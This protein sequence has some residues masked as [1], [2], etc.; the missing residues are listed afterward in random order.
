MASIEKEMNRHRMFAWVLSGVEGMLIVSIAAQAVSDPLRII[1]DPFWSLASSMRSTRMPMLWIAMHLHLS[2]KTSCSGKRV[3]RVVVFLHAVVSQL[4]FVRYFAG[5]CWVAEP[6]MLSLFYVLFLIFS[7]L[8]RV[9]GMDVL[10]MERNHTRV[11]GLFVYIW[12]SIGLVTGE[13]MQLYAAS[14]VLVVSVVGIGSIGLRA[15]ALLARMRILTEMASAVPWRVPKEFFT[16]NVSAITY[17]FI[18]SI[19]DKV[20]VYNMSL[21]NLNLCE[22]G[23]EEND[24]IDTARFKFFQMSELAMKHPAVLRRIAKCHG[25]VVSVG[26]YIRRERKE[27][28]ECTAQMRKERGTMEAKRWMS[29][30]QV[31]LSNNKPKGL[32]MQKKVH[33]VR[34]IRS[35]N[36]IEILVSRIRYLY[37]IKV[38]Q[39]RYNEAVEAFREIR[40]FVEFLDG[41]KGEY[42]LLGDLDAMVMLGMKGLRSEALETEKLIAARLP[43]D[44]FAN[45]D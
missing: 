4:L 3:S 18:M 26:E 15:L 35:Y 6:G 21:L 14:I 7:S 34:R 12:S 11:R 43:S 37:K 9:F 8:L 17:F 24:D 33:F 29:V 19:V 10:M 20:Y 5:G 41:Y 1:I 22:Y 13:V 30:P 23:Y 28:L 39:S 27:I 44:V 36:F 31:N 38:L 32:V 2:C 45:D 40:R 25:S 16:A 42:L